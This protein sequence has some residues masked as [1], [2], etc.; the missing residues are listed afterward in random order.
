MKIQ[1]LIATDDCDY[2]EHLSNILAGEHADAIEV[3]VCS[4]H[5]NLHEHLD[6]RE[7]DVAL[8]EASM[9]ESADMQSI[10]L[11]LLLW[12]EDGN[13]PNIPGEIKKIR[14]YQRI[15]SMVSSMLELYAREQAAES[16]SCLKRAL[17]T[18]VWSPVGGAGKT[19]VALAHSAGKA[20]GGKQ[21]MYL[22][23][24]PFSSVS[25]YFSEAGKSV[26]AVF[27]MLEA[28]KGNIKMLIRGIRLQDNASEITYFCRPDNFD[29]MNI[30]TAENIAALIGACS[31][32]TDE[33]V[34][35][36]SS[37]C[38]ERTRKVFELADRI[39]LVT[40]T[41]QTA[42]IKYSQFASQH[43][44]FQRI[45]NKAALVA[46][47]G[48]MVNGSLVDEV[49]CLPLVQS[50]DAVAVYKTLSAIVAN[51][52]HPSVRH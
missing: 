37:A 38:D 4:C 23:L 2:A 44:I 31:E 19:T 18:A 36:M 34:I 15:S 14:K 46:N 33:L 51:Q 6:S 5:E 35:D 50:P 39:L 40:D 49:I 47:K 16:G 3:S 26:S 27:E 43:N 13:A 17:I 1:L 52:C 25:A 8:L 12:P 30:L 10:H 28:G 41:T 42:Q 22:N 21:V 20:S 32:V 9:I 45:K 24:E 7:F 48:A 11:P 29:D